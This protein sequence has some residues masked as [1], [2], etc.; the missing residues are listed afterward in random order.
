[1][2]ERS[3]TCAKRL[4]RKVFC[5]KCPVF[6][7]IITPLAQQQHP[8]AVPH[9]SWIP[10]ACLPLGGVGSLDPQGGHQK[11]LSYIQFRHRE[12][13]LMKGMEQQKIP[14]L[15]EDS[16][17]QPQFWFHFPVLRKNFVRYNF[18][19]IYIPRH[20]WIFLKDILKMSLLLLT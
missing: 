20:I 2:C 4:V 19:L 10:Q 15:W 9:P 7:A 3:K 13:M 8:L 6:I 18:H 11:W 14:V 5:A 17:P 1:M 16:K 12:L